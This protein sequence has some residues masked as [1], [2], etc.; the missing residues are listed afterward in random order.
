MAAVL[1]LMLGTSSLFLTRK[2]S[3]GVSAAPASFTVTENGAPAASAA[4]PA[5]AL[6]QD[7]AVD[8]RAAAA[9]HGAAPPPMASA[10]AA[11]VARAANAV[12]NVPADLAAEAQTTNASPKLA[13][14]KKARPSAGGSAFDEVPGSLG[15]LGHG[16]PSGV[17]DLKGS[18]TAQFSPAPPATPPAPSK[19]DSASTPGGAP[20]PFAAAKAQYNQGDYAGAAQA[21]DGLA[22]GGD[23]T[24]GYWAARSVRDGSDGCA[25]AVVKYDAV[26]N[27]AWGTSA[28][29][30]A[31]YDAANCYARMG[32]TSAALARFQR[33]LTVPAYATRAQ[34]GINSISMVASK[35]RAMAKA[36]PPA[37]AAAPAA[38]AGSST[39]PASAADAVKAVGK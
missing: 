39:P 24:A 34:S 7:R 19:D 35:P 22:A 4:S 33:L 27:S 20:T 36:P 23:T 21:F 32:Q 17:G 3:R 5:V 38:P 30:D 2:V 9:A 18:A 29:Y 15:A 10:A 28:G 16:G 25:A 26:S 8:P 37:A 12:E 31:T 13:M 11:P 1:L 14:G 6:E